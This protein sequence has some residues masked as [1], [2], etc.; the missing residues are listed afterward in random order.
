MG[1]QLCA[2]IIWSAKGFTCS[3]SKLI[4]QQHSRLSNTCC[5]NVDVNYLANVNGCNKS[6]YEIISITAWLLY[7]IAHNGGFVVTPVM[8]GDICHH[9]KRD[10]CRRKATR[11]MT[12]INLLVCRQ[13]AMR[14]S[15]LIDA[16]DESNDLKKNCQMEC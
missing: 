2:L 12:L 8:N 9:A 16:G 13:N 10:S 3:D 15:L 14:L 6:P 11:E 4:H 1:I 7:T 5:I